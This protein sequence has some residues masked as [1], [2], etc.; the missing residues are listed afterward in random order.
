M[1]WNSGYE[2]MEKDIIDTYNMGKLSKDTLEKI[3]SP[4][5]GTDCDSGGSKHL[6]SNDGLCVEHIICLTM[7]PEETKEV[8]DNPKWDCSYEEIGVTIYND[9]TYPEPY[10]TAN[11]RAYD[12][13]MSIW[14]DIW[15]MW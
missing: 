3:M 6:L 7:K 8:I 2:K 13:F 14:R 12:L 1:G 10:W 11:E 15:G 9:E 5:M 4:Y